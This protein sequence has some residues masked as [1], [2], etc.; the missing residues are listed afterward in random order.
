MMSS[1]RRSSMRKPKA[2]RPGDLIGVIAPSGPPDE[3]ELMAGIQRLKGLGFKVRLGE[4]LLKRWRHLAAEDRERAEDLHR[5]FKDPE[6]RAIV[7]A[8][9]GSGASRL[10]PHLDPK[11]IQANPKIFVGSSDVTTILLYLT[12]TGGLVA[13]H[14]PMAAPNFGEKP[15]ALTDEFFLKL[16]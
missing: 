15:S 4:H 10:I 14:G 12:Q 7:C 9:G 13:F 3:K 8:R 6:I 1:T 11:I 16:L 2:L 5:L